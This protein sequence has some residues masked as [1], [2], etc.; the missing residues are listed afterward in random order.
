MR[1]TATEITRIQ[2][3]FTTQ[4][5]SGHD[6]TMREFIDDTGVGQG[7]WAMQESFTQNPYLPGEKA[8]EAPHRAN[9]VLEVFHWHTCP[10]F[11]CYHLSIDC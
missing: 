6:I 5:G 3:Q 2:T 7:V 10:F 8:V 11:D 4:V 9:S 1:D